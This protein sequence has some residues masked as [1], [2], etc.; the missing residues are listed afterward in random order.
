MLNGNSKMEL[1]RNWNE[2]LK[3]YP[4]ESLR[5]S[6]KELWTADLEGKLKRSVER[7]TDGTSKGNLN[8]WNLKECWREL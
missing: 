2:S 5:G 8:K 6:L 3:G 7:N 4:K 1:K